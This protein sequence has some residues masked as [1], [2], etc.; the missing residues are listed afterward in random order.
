MFTGGIQLPPP[1]ESAMH[2][3]LPDLPTLRAIFHAD[4]DTGTLTNRSTGHVYAAVAGRN[5]KTNLVHVGG[6]TYL[7]SRVL[8]KMY[9]GRDPGPL[10]VDHISRDRTDNRACNLRAV[11]A[12]E[13]CINKECYSA[14][15][16]RGVYYGKM[17]KDGSRPYI[18]MV[19][20]T[21][22]RDPATGKHIRKTHKYGQF[23]RLEDAVARAAE[24]HEAWGVQ[25]YMPA[26]DYRANVDRLQPVTMFDTSVIKEAV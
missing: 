2:K 26:A 4:P 23:E 25:E 22:G 21:Y 5:N 8:Y 14:T 7:I 15:G 13:N 16:H 17:R 9:T 24:V 20:R 11:T 12:G 1:A 10:V 19:H 6:T 18:V 3:R